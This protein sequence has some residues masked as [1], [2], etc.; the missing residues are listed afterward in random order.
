MPRYYNDK[1]TAT[2]IYLIPRWKQSLHD[3]LKH[4]KINGQRPDEQ[5]TQINPVEELNKNLLQN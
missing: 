1:T 3:D 2:R 4:V 5:Q